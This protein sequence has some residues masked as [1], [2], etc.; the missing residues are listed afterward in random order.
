V[1]VINDVDK[2]SAHGN[3]SH[4]ITVKFKINLDYKKKTHTHTKSLIFELLTALLQRIGVFWDMM[5]YL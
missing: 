1:Y 4:H 3:S 5:M 2:F